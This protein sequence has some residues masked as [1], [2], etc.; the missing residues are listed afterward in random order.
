V[1]SVEGYEEDTMSTFTRTLTLGLNTLALVAGLALPTGAATLTVTRFDDPNPDGC[2]PTDCSL[3]E[4]VQLA[5]ALSGADTVLLAAGLYQ[6]TRPGAGEDANL[7]GDLDSSGPLEI[8][9]VGM[10]QTTILGVGLG[11]RLLQASANLALRDLRLENGHA[12]GGFSGGALYGLGNLEVARIEVV[13]C[14]ANDGGAVS[15]SGGTV[16]LTDAVFEGNSSSYSG[17]AISAANGPFDVLRS[18]FT[19]NSALNSA[20]PGGAIALYATG[21]SPV[22]FR[23][24]DSTFSL[25]TAGYGG[26]I[27][28]TAGSVQGGDPPATLDATIVRS[29][30]SDNSAFGAPGGG[31]IVTAPRGPNADVLTLRLVDCVLQDNTAASGGG[32]VVGIGVLTARETRFVGN[33]A[34]DSGGAI[35]LGALNGSHTG[36]A[37]IAGSTFEANTSANDGGGIE[38]LG[39]LEVSES[40]FVANTA[41]GNGGGVFAGGGTLVTRSTFSGNQAASGGGLAQGDSFV[42]VFTSTF[43][44]NVATSSGAALFGGATTFGNQLRVAGNIIS[45]TCSGTSG[46]SVL[47]DGHNVESPGA[48]CF[49]FPDATDL[50]SVSEGQLALGPLESDGRTSFHVPGASSVARDRITGRCGDLDQRLFEPVDPACDAGSV[51]VGAQD[52]VTFRDGFEVGLAGWSSAVP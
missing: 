30:F 33:G 51:E 23:V 45:G 21:S 40:S 52:S 8:V 19:G 29:T 42:Q 35:W 41:G 46:L 43:R 2:T 10:S 14:S 36:S 13:G 15:W 7:T 12:P 34:T 49:L 27:A 32:L 26:A 47:S 18:T 22:S 6:L 44:D 9:G 48:S 17:G 28:L 3:R 31:A 25:N 37:Y 20:Y 1:F 4:A 24:T 50:T 16:T 5:N 38:A 39:G 11:D